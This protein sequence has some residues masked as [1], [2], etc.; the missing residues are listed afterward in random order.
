M[1]EK[2]FDMRETIADNRL[3]GLWRMMTGY[4]ALYLA[5]VVCI[6]LATVARSGIYFLLAY[7]VD[8]VLLA[9]SATVSVALVAAG[10][11]VLAVLQGGFTFLGGRWAA[12]TSES[13]VRRLR[14][15]LYDHVQRLSFTYHDK[16]QT[17]ELLQRS[18]S[19]V[20]TLRR[21]YAE[22]T[23]GFGRITLMFAV[24]F[25]ALLLL[26][27]RLAFL[28]II[29]IPIVIIISLFFFKKM[30]SVFEAFQQ[31]EAVLSNTL[32][33]NLTGVRVVKAFARQAYESDKFEG[34]NIEKYRR[35]IKLTY[36][37]AAYW[38]ATDILCSLQMLFGFTV[39]ALMT[40]NGTISIGMY[41][42]YMGLVVQ[43]I[44]PIRGLGRLIAEMS[45]GFVAYHRIMEI[46]RV[47]REPLDEGSFAPVRPIQ[48][49]LAFENVTFAYEGEEPVLHNISFSVESGQTVAFMGST[50]SGKT[51]LMNLLPRFYNFQE[52]RILLD[53][54]PL[55]DYPRGYLR[56]HIG[57]VQQ[58][59]FLFS[60]SIRDNITY[61]VDRHV[62]DDEVEAAAREA[63]VH[64]VIMSFPKGYDTMVG[65]RG[66][67]L[68]G[69]Q[70]QRVTVARMLL[71]Q[72]QILIF[73]DA[74]SSVDTET[75]A[76]MRKA[77]LEQN[78]SRTTL[79]IAHR[80]QSVMSADQIF[81]LD[82]GRIVQRGTHRE[83]VAEE[84]IYRNVYDLQA[85]IEDELQRDLADAA[86]AAGKANGRNVNGQPDGSELSAGK[87]SLA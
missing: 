82:K 21:F 87:L 28:S 53:G 55:T 68:S 9:Q 62:T 49:A 61:G 80:I 38:P 15:Y 42:A 60:R 57:I 30:Y 7:F 54:K 69:G 70:K 44:W 37:H 45:T 18:T 72:P 63:A 17:G 1:T 24:N 12:K 66:V 6:G 59:P 46:M 64:D 31:Q 22:Q 52:G 50:G 51:S 40:I 86:V 25:T 3:L 75:E 85:R 58:E 23:I 41:L 47:D 65:E 20:D 4:R 29:V 76:V 14:D 81:V 78:A 83:L 39:G 36:M 11:I 8:D 10:F 77:I 34:D 71:K 13:I 5:A 16:M 2:T 35:G 27:V 67:T 48:G 84:G 74:T 26:D 56:Q 79:V 73:D 19:D 32:Q 33:E 43:I